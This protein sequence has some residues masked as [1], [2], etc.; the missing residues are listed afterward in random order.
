MYN[1]GKL[2]IDN[3]WNSETADYKQEREASLPHSCDQWVIGGKQEIQWL[4]EDLQEAL[5]KLN[6][7]PVSE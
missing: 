5:K 6:N 1:K 4:I 7:E 3:Q 2:S